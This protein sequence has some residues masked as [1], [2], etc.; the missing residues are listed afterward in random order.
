MQ[1][2]KADSWKGKLPLFL[3]LSRTPHAL[4]DIATPALAALLW[5]GEFPPAWVIAVGLVAALGGYI[6]V[7][8]LNDIADY[9]VDIK[10]LK[11]GSAP[12]ASGDL[13]DA[14]IR[15]PLARGLLTLREAVLWAGSWGVLA[16]LG[17][18]LLNPVCAV[19][20]LAAAGLEAIYCMLLTVTCLRSA[21]N[22]VVKTAGATA[23]VFAVESNPSL[24]FLMFLFL[25]IFFWEI[26][27]QNVPHDWVDMEEDRA[28]DAKT[29]P[30]KLG[31]RKAAWLVA[32]VLV[33]STIFGMLSGVVSGSSLGGVYWA[34][35]VV[36]SLF[37]LFLPAMALFR[38]LDGRCASA[39]FN[40]ASYYPVA[41]LVSWLLE[42][43]I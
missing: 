2:L 22:G 16:F 15:H 33:L 20:F 28:L 34:G 5:L 13:D 14:L 31:P 23:A 21:I 32:F 42:W 37:L 10:R 27:G 4:I 17:A 19:I 8:A 41:L 29:I 6:S 11:I 30:L 1:V 9:Y 40:R 24:F 18:M 12:N 38:T 39:L 35:F 25:W 7:Y 3:A 26:G 36:S 43:I